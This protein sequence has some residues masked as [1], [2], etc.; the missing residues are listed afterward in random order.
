[1]GSNTKAMEEALQAAVSRMNQPQAAPTHT[2]PL[3]VVAAVLP[4]LL[5]NREDRQDIAEKIDGLRTEDLAPL[6][7]QIQLVRQKLHRLGKAQDTMMTALDQLREQ[8]TAIGEAVLELV[9]Q[10]ARV[11]ILDEAPEDLEE[12]VRAPARRPAAAPRRAPAQAPKAPRRVRKNAGFD[13]S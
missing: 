10:M 3:G 2:D 6:R 9:R 8:Q 11:Q 7:E 12:E 4:R 13:Q 1:M 5:E